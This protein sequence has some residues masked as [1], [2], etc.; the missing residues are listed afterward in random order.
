MGP[1]SAVLGLADACGH[2]HWGSR[3]NSL[4][5]HETLYWVWRTHVATPAGASRAAP[6][7]ATKRC[8]GCGGRMWPT[9]LGRCVG[10]P[11]GQQSA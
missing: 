2:P 10:P 11:M 7:R 9:P 4:W 5:G 1:R 3:W 6:Y 8:T